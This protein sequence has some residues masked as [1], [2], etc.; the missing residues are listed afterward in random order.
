MELAE[1]YMR[2]EDRQKTERPEDGYD[3]AGSENMFLDRKSNENEPEKAIK[4]RIVGLVV[5]TTTIK[6][7]I[8][9]I[10]GLIVITRLLRQ[11]MLRM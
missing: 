10:I 3:L 2:A 9:I 8:L 7:V 6:T 5:A 11:I 1:I 4:I